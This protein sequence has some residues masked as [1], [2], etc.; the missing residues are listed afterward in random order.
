MFFYVKIVK[1]TAEGICEQPI[2]YKYNRHHKQHEGSKI[3]KLGCKANCHN[4]NETKAT[5]IHAYSITQ[6]SA[7]PMTDTVMK[8]VEELAKLLNSMLETP[9]AIKDEMDKFS[10]TLP[11]YKTVIS[12]YGSDPLCVHNLLRRSAMSDALST[13]N[14]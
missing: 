6:V 9:A 1:G 11:G 4:Y 10:S 12:L 8:M 5:Q 3:P 2:L 7:Q 13:L 14:Q